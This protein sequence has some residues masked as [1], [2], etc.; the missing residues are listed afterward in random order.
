MMK[1]GFAVA[2]KPKILFSR[3]VALKISGAE[4]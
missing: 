3:T 2:A 1:A 4:G